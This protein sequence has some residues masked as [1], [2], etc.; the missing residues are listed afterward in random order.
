MFSIY[1]ISV[2]SLAADGCQTIFGLPKKDILAAYQF[3]CEQAL[4]NCGFLYTRDRDCLTALFLYLVNLRERGWGAAV[5][6]CYADDAL[7]TTILD[8]IRRCRRSS[9][10]VLYIWRDGSHCA[11]NGYPKRVGEC[12]VHRSRG[13]DAPKA[14]V[15]DRP[16]RRSYRRT[17]RLQAHNPRTPPGT[18]GSL[19]T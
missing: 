4:L 2:Q 14:L 1:C 17:K 13:R 11:K 6:L 10:P 15:G 19:S 5:A 18:A 7:L 12:Q 8:L 9:I 3:G 16:L